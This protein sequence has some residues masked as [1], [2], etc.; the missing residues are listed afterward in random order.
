MIATIAPRAWC[1]TIPAV[2]FD[3]GDALSP[4]AQQGFGEAMEKIEGFCRSP[5]TL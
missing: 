4:E 5:Q 3:F 2:K 1:L